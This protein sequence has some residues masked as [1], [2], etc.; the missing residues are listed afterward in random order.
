[1]AL[2]TLSPHLPAKSP[3][4]R[5]GG[6]GR[7]PVNRSRGGDWG[8]G[9]GGD[10][11]PDYG[12]RLRR[13]RLGMAVALVSIV[14]V[15]VCFSAAFLLR[16]ASGVYDG[17]SGTIVH[18]WQPLLLPLNLLWLNTIVL[19]A[20]SVTIELA[21]RHA[22]EQAA[23]APILSIPGIKADTRYVPWL[24]ITIALG[25]TFLGGQW[26]AWADM[27]RHGWWISSGASSSFFY[28]LT[29]TH[30][31]HLLGGILALLYAEALALRHKPVEQR[32]IVVDVTAWY[33]HVIDI[34]WIYLFALLAYGG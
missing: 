28:I 27:Q 19:L 21:K 23:L 4:L 33:W 12:E 29:G 13:C 25:F 1:M 9:R 6:G 30:A 26:L 5:A 16:Q 20:S 24:P 7:P 22:I 17:A 15:F 11:A 2:G 32:R 31:L 34:L 18:D 10:G 8:G 14:M 3:K